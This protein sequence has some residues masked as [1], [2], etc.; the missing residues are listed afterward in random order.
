MTPFRWGLTVASFVMAIG[1]S[2]YVIAS[3]WPAGGA[4]LGL[5]VWAHL[6]AVG[7]VAFDIVM[8]VL[9]VQLSA[10]AVGAPMTFGTSLRMSFGGDFAASIT[11]SR[12]G[13]EPARFLV[14]REA[15]YPVGAVLVVLFMELLLEMLSVVILT[16]LFFVFLDH[17]SAVVTA[18]LAI[19][20]GFAALLIGGGAVALMVSRRHS[21]GP[22]PG[23]ARVLGIG[24]GAWRRV[25]RL[26]RHLRESIASLQRARPG[27]VSLALVC[28]VLHVAARLAVLPLLVY[29]YG[30]RP[31]L[32]PLVVWPLVLLYG[33]A[34]APAPAGGGVVELSF[35]AALASHIPAR[36]LASSLIWWRVYSFYIGLVLGALAAGRTVMRALRVDRTEQL[37]AELEGDSAVA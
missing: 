36:L 16:A 13:G 7:L 4:P 26:L 17:S 31:P 29:A 3:S 9:K 32:A 35:K 6:V 37:M 34:M 23:W 8:R 21:G 1:M 24:A 28:S 12:S 19:V 18:L 11:P 22:P 14:M 2:V 27:Y 30:D 25:Q 5:P 15:G 10:R 33:S 20:G